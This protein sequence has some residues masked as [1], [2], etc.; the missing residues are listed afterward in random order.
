MLVAAQCSVFSDRGVLFALACFLIFKVS[1]STD[2]VFLSSSCHG[3]CG[4]LTLIRLRED[5]VRQWI[6]LELVLSPD[7]A[8]STAKLAAR[9]TA[10]TSAAVR[11]YFSNK[12]PSGDSTDPPAYVTVEGCSQ[13]LLKN[14]VQPSVRRRGRAAGG[15][16]RKYS[17]HIL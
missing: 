15:K 3:A 9:L 7:S 17:F 8:N 6:S 5:S 14:K 4:P 12:L 1:D 2:C 16:T 13:Q 11:C 10:A